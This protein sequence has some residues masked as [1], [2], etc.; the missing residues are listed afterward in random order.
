MLFTKRRMQCNIL[1]CTVKFVA[2]LPLYTCSDNL[3]NSNS[4]KMCLVSSLVLHL[5]KSSRRKI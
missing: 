3:Q 1:R 4:V 5:E 2:K